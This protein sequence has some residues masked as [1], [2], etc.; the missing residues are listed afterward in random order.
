MAQ[1][2]GRLAR[3]SDRLL[4]LALGVV[5]AADMGAAAAR[6]Q[7]KPDSGEQD[8][9]DPAQRVEGEAILDL[10]DAAM[11]GK[12]VPMDFAIRWHTDF[13]KAQQGTFVPFTVLVDGTTLTQTSALLYVR[14]VA[15]DASRA[16][17]KGSA[18]RTRKPNRKADRHA[19]DVPYPV[20]VIYAVNLTAEEGQPARVSRGFSVSPGEYDLYL[21][22]RERLGSRASP[23]AAV[24]K[25]SLVVPNFWTDELMTSSVILADRLVVLDEPATPDQLLERPYAIGLNDVQPA[26]DSKFRKDEELICVFLV[27]NPKVSQDRKFDVQVEYHFFRKTG[28]PAKLDGGEVSEPAGERPQ[29]REGEAYVN[30]TEPQR[31]NAAIMGAQFDPA[32][33]PI[34]AGQGV[35]LAGF[36]EGD[37]RLMIKVTDLLA[38]KTLTR[39]VTFTV[40]S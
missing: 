9:I 35:P 16:A 26:A 31:F 29:P 13:L 23:R 20:D 40:G 10:A 22:L 12:P 24:L 4:P 28:E 33:H 32:G 3:L 17:P 37:Y 36:Q 15:R 27:Y 8:R 30:H 7:G 25:E 6:A 14:A 39:D 21:V 11:A 18:D 19:G 34:M 38:G 2:S 1:I 5:I